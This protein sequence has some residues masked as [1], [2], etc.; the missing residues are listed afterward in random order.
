MPSI[1]PDSAYVQTF[2][3]A[4][5]TTGSSVV[6]SPASALTDGLIISYARV[7]AANTVEVKFYNAAT[8]TAVGFNTMNWYITVVR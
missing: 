8:T 2:T 4:N 6:V 7:S 5:A 3:V 1:G